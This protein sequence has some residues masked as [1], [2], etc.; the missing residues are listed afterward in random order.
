MFT[1]FFRLTPDNP[2]NGGIVF[3]DHSKNDRSGHLGHALVEY[4]PGQLIAYFADCSATEPSHP[5]HSGH[6]W[7]KYKRSF[8]GGKTWSEPQDEIY[9]KRSYEETDGLTTLMI[10]KAVV[11][12]SGRIV[13]FYL[14][15]D[16][17]VNGHIWEPYKNP[18]YTYSDDQGKTWCEPRELFP[19]PG[20]VFDARYHEGE[21]YVLFQK[22]DPAEKS[23]DYPYYLF[24]SSDQGESW[25]ERST[26]IFEHNFDCF[27]G[28][29]IF[30]E[31]G[32]LLLYTYDLHDE[33]NLR[34][35]I[36][37]DKGKTWSEPRRSF[38][39]KR[40]RNPQ[41]A[42]LGGKYLIHGRSGSRGAEKAGHIVLYCSENGI[43]WDEGIYL[44]KRVARAGA[45][46]NNILV[47]DKD[48]NERLL[49]QSSHA[50]HL[51]KTN[52]LHFFVDVK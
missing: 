25:E 5:G 4:A 1:D 30:R 49:I 11:T 47:H 42:R 39:K 2:P 6:G 22:Q 18:L 28:T 12:D 52:V 48:G 8:D 26:P 50:Y 23:T 7:M 27:Y 33:Y 31:D 20:R 9:S 24:V 10:E 32:S 45:Y 19:M 43:T 16:L 15:C 44:A 51:Y 17:A 37:N 21:I 13:L 34:Y 41:I 3:T 35:V 46:S 36:S 40:L 14:T 38:F 29:M